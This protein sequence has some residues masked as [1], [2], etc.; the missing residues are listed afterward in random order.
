MEQYIEQLERNGEHES[1][2]LLQVLLPLQRQA[3]FSNKP[4]SADA[5][6]S[7]KKCREAVNQDFAGKLKLSKRLKIKYFK[8]LI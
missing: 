4:V 3:A 7:L 2:L 1:A 8:N 5:A 6:Y